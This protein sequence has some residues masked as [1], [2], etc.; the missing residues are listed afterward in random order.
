M[1]QDV[2]DFEVSMHG[3]DFMQPS[4]SVNDL[5]KEDSGFILC[6]SFLFIQVMF[7]IPSIT[8]LHSNALSLFG[9]EIV[10]EPNNIFVMT[11]FEYSDFCGYKFL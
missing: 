9:T 5:F 11:F 2:S 7:K 8:I 1:Q 10:D 3:I 4:K 6:E